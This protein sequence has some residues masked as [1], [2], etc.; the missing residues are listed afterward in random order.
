MVAMR[1][2]RMP[3]MLLE[4]IQEKNAAKKEYQNGKD[5]KQIDTEKSGSDIL[6]RI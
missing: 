1:T 6:G 2:K 3:R 4:K 5:R